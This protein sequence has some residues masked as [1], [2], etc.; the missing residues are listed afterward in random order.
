MKKKFYILLFIFLSYSLSKNNPKIALVLSGGGA[1][2]IAQIPTLELIDSLNIPIDLIIGTSMGSITGAT[3]SMGHSAD[4]MKKM[5]FETNWDIAFSN[6]KE[7][8]KL[9]FFQK[10]DHDKYRAMF[11]LD[12]ISPIPPIAFT[13]GHNSYMNLNKTVGIYETITN[14]DDL[15]IPFRCNAVD[16]LSGNEIIFENGSLSKSLRASSS[17]PSVFSPLKD[18]DLLLVDGGVVNNFPADVADYLNVD[19]IIGVNVALSKKEMTDITTIFD[20]LSQSILL[21]G[22]KKRIENL[23][24]TDILI[25]PDVTKSS[26]L[27]FDYNSMIEI[28]NYGK[29]AAYSKLED[30]IKLKESLNDKSPTPITFNSINSDSIVFKNIIINSIDNISVSDIFGFNLPV[31]L[32]KDDFLD[33]MADLRQSNKYI[34]INYKIY[35]NNS[36]YSLNLNIE[37]APIRIINKVIIKDNKKLSKVF[38]QDILNINSG[39]VLDIDK[40][41]MNINSAYGLD[42][43]ESI[44]YEIE[45]DGQNTN[46]I[47]IVKEA[48]YNKLKLSGG[49]H[50]YYKIIGQ[51]KFDLLDVPFK[52]FRLTDEITFGNDLRKNN[53]NIYYI[54]N[55]NFQSWLIPL[56]K[57]NNTKKKVSIYNNEN[58]L[59]TQNLYDR[60][61]SLNTIIPLKK[62]GHI[63]FG[64]HKQKNKYQYNINSEL[65]KYYSLNI[66]IDQIDNLLYPKNGYYYNMS[67]EK[68]YNQYQYNLTKL[69]FDHFIN[70]TSFGRIKLYGDAIYSNLSNFQNILN[71]KSIHYFSYDRTLSFSEYSLMV[72]DLISYGLEINFDYKNSTTIRLIYNCIDNAEFKHNNDNIYDFTSY[73]FGFRIKSILGPFNF[74][75]TKTNDELYNQSKNNYFFSLGIDY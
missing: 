9:Y 32:K 23:Q 16:L 43:F 65:I 24:Y 48:T 54:N 13:N 60:D 28:Y 52:K 33:L 57:I 71:A 55:F 40:I 34:H 25:E 64:L 10:K 3:Y 62:Y 2:G 15:Y 12:G 63:N 69:D 17:I 59:I 22:L 61:Y 53:I 27:N 58:N 7:R 67:F 46:L 74:M 5:A 47:F 44:R 14:F 19:F 36:S 21:N 20:V 18:N 38:I 37:K 11:E 51:M 1:K 39:D 42:Y 35:E 73:G 4:E 49:W 8:D 75:W 26:T 45:Y 41:R 30:L 66:N 56:I 31:T 6:S 72:T 70:L 68:G 29:K 50:N